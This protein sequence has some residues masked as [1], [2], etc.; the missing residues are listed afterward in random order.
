ME[1]PPLSE[2]V[3]SYFTYRKHQRKIAR[4][5]YARLL[6]AALFLS[7]VP[8]IILSILVIYGRLTLGEGIFA[9]ILALYGSMFFA[10]PYLAD[11]SALT[12]YVNQL[13]LDR[14]TKMPP[15]SFLSNVEELSQSVSKLHYS[16]GKRRRQLESALA[17][18]RLLF[19]T[20]PDILLMIDGSLEIVR[21]NHAAFFKL[22]NNL[23]RQRLENVIVN[24][25]FI[26]K[27]QEAIQSRH[28]TTCEITLKRHNVVFDYNIRIECLPYD[29]PRSIAALIILHDI[30]ESKK[31]RQTIK[32]FVANASH[33]IRTPLTGIIGFIETIQ[34][35]DRK[36]HKM[37]DHFL[38]LMAEQAERMANLVND[39]LSLSKVEINEGTPP[40][41][42]T[43]IYQIVSNVV[44][45]MEL[46]ASKAQKEITNT[47]SEDLPEVLGDSNALTQVFTNLISNAIKYS[48]PDST[49]TLNAKIRKTKNNAEH[50]APRELCIEIK[51]ESEGIPRKHLSRIT[52][53]FYRIESKE[54]AKIPGTGLG[55]SIVKHILHRHRG[56]LEVKSKAK[57]GS[58]FTAVL[59]LFEQAISY[60]ND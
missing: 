45:R 52:E 49:I 32:D 22:R 10:K 43:N 60:K 51:D 6:K 7:I 47:L 55:L 57:Q 46:E 2:I 8:I 34:G 30:T 19:D 39:L 58:T 21:A 24:E 53:R 41:E 48:K 13:S 25:E 33:E 16:W 23:I 17:E 15:L 42:M 5:Y 35:M 40:T 59:P 20:I 26:E 54:N 29:A 18:S 38:S 28:S 37:R 3:A 11:L 36:E 50:H 27:V 1:V 56:Y 31:S 9:S 4:V 14:D 44:R 12:Y